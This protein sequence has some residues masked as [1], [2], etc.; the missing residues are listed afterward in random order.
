M[1]RI[2]LTRKD[3]NNP[4]RSRR[5]PSRA[6][7][8]VGGR[9]LEA[10]GPVP[11]Y[12]LVTLLWLHGHGGERFEVHDD[13]SPTGRPG[14]LAM[15]GQVRNWAR[16]VSGKPA[17]D[18]DASSEVDFSPHERGLVSRAAGRV[19]GLAEMESPQP[20]NARPCATLPSDGP[21]HPRGGDRASTGLASAHRSNA[22]A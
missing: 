12:K 15:R 20:E 13:R 9:H 7:C 10:T 4:G 19:A 5:H 1:I 2:D 14:G 8:E 21:K 11:I 18:K 17:F 22:A 16:L 6:S 3:T